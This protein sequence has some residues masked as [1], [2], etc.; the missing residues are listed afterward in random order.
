MGTNYYVRENICD[1]CGRYDEIH[2]GKSSGGWCF[3]L[4]IYPS[5]GINDLKDWIP[6]LQ[7]KK[8]FNEY[9]EEVSYQKLMDTITNR[10]WVPRTILSDDFLERNY[11]VNGP[12]GLLRTK[13][14]GRFCVAHGEGTWDLV[15]GDFS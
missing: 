1:C 3:T 7:G 11:A 2:I 10:S 12:N 8:I 4:R 5:K 15:I 9:D 6:F 14:N 13:I